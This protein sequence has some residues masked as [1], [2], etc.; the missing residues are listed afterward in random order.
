MATQ[1][2]TIKEFQ[3][4]LQGLPN[5]VQKESDVMVREMSED[6]A[7]RMRFNAPAGSSPW[8]TGALKKDIKATKRGNKYA[9]MGPRHWR[10]V[11]DG[12]TPNSNVIPVELAEGHKGSPGSTVGRTLGRSFDTKGFIRNPGPMRAYGFVEKSQR[13]FESESLPKII[14]RG[15]NR[16]FSK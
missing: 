3:G 1:V 16:A 10:I 14:E 7:R 4:Y 9:I 13:A 8:A 6:M 12:I 11:N 2:F 15:L 5:K